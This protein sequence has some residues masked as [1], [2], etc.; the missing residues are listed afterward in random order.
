MWT[1]AKPGSEKDKGRVEWGR[2]EGSNGDM[3]RM[4]QAWDRA[5]FIVHAVS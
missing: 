3:V 1:P 4:D 5:G 2:E